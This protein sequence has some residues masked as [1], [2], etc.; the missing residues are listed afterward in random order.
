MKSSWFSHPIQYRFAKCIQDADY[1]RWGT[2]LFRTFLECSVATLRQS[3]RRM[4]GDDICP[5]IESEYMRAIK[6]VPKPERFS[7]AFAILTD[8]LEARPHDFLGSVFMALGANDA[9]FRGQCFTPPAVCDMMAAMTVHDLRPKRPNSDRT[10]W[11]NEP[12]CGGGQMILSVFNHLVDNGWGPRDF[13]FVATDVDWRCFAMAYVQTTLCDVPCVVEHGNTLSLETYIQERNLSSILHPP[14]NWPNATETT[15]AEPVDTIDSQTTETDCPALVG[16]GS[17]IG[18]GPETGL[19]PATYHRDI[20][21]EQ[22]TLF[23]LA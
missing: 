1:A 15:H 21:W 23:E 13:H 20:E 3:V 10:V 9:K 4:I 6:T 14:R 5:K 18:A 19:H 11:I 8:A 22:T 12:C 2:E 16:A 7:E 17:P